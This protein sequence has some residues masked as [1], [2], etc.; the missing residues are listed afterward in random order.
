MDSLHID[1]LLST[2]L[3]DDQ[4][5]DLSSTSYDIIHN[6]F[7]NSNDY[8]NTLTKI[9]LLS[10]SNNKLTDDQFRDFSN[11]MLLKEIEILDIS[12]NH[13]TPWP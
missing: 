5:L 3:Y 8:Q 11:I 2:Y 4:I 1:D 9:K 12:N 13:L 10:L 7:T 6:V